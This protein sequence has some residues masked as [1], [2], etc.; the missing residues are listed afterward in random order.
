[1]AS[2]EWI[3]KFAQELGVNIHIWGRHGRRYKDQIENELGVKLCDQMSEFVESVGNISLF[4]VEILVTG[5]DDKYNCIV[6]T[7]DAREDAAWLPRTV[8]RIVKQEENM[9]YES[10]SGNIV[11]FDAVPFE[12]YR[13]EEFVRYEDLK[14]YIR[15]LIETDAEPNPFEKYL[16]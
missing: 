16:Q 7:I 2:R 8:I 1:M 10:D 5:V 15:Y 9:F 12:P 11:G 6:S 3:E 4:G 14:S 13:A